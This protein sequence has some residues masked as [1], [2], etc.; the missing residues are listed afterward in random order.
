MYTFTMQ[1]DPTTP[2][3]RAQL[4]AEALATLAA[5]MPPD[6][7]TAPHEVCDASDAEDISIDVGDRVSVYPAGAWEPRIATVQAVRGD[8]QYLVHMAFG[9]TKWVWERDI[10]LLVK[11]AAL[12][13]QNGVA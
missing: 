11:R 8:G 6:S 12:D 9:C 2:E 1:P 4:R 5:T 10:T 13:V 3:R 7:P